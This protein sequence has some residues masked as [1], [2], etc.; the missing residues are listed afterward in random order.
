MNKRLIGFKDISLLTDEPLSTLNIEELLKL[1]DL[2][3]ESPLESPKASW[4]Q[5]YDF[6]LD[7]HS[8]FDIPKPKTQ[9]EKERLV[10]G[11]ISGLRKLFDPE[12]N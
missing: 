1:P 6:S 7:G 9:E 4:L 12:N 5:T 8:P 11:F 3:R 10:S 2:D